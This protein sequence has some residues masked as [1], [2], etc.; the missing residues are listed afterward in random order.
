[1]VT[2]KLNDEHIIISVTLQI[3]EHKRNELNKQHYKKQ[4]H[5]ILYW[6]SF[7]LDVAA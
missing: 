1:V 7:V 5:A 4:K 6:N 2:E 3:L